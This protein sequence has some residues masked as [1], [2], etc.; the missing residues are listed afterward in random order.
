M[1]KEKFNEKLKKLGLTQKDFAKIVG[2]SHQAIK[3]WQSGKIPRWV[4]IMLEYFE[5]LYVS[6]EKFE[7]YIKK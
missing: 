4:E 6:S 2:Y 5:E 3:Q 7:K 1:T